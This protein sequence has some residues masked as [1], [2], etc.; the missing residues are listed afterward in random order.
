MP[1]LFA[2]V[3]QAKQNMNHKIWYIGII[4]LDSYKAGWAVAIP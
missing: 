1:I 4:D 3:L 2:F